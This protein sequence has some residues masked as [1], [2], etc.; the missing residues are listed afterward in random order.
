M[1]YSPQGELGIDIGV[2]RG[3]FKTM[4]K[5]SSLDDWKNGISLKMKTG[6]SLKEY[7]RYV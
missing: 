4:I 5:G 7:L 1:E 6:L 3:G 2:E